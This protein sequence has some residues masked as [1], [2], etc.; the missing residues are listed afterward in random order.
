MHLLEEERPA[1]G[2]TVGVLA[3]K[4]SAVVS[5]LLQRN[6]LR[7]IVLPVAEIERLLLLVHR[8]IRQILSKGLPT[9]NKLETKY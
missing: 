3:H 5:V 9:Q 4:Y 2:C 8:L 1:S 6:V 7:L